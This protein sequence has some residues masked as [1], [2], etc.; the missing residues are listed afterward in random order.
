MNKNILVAAFVKKDEGSDFLKHI[1]SEFDIEA[2]K[3]FEFDIMDDSKQSLYTFYIDIPVGERINL[4]DYFKNALI[5]HKKKK[6]F[7][8]INALNKLIEKE[9]DLVGG[10]ID[11]KK[12]KIN[13][14]KFSNNLIL[15]SNNNL[16]IIQ[17]KRVFS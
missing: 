17:I 1:K 16:S 6:T 13:W 9:Y 14:D 11:Y 4:R 12:Y 8:T 3:V 2:S 5:V 15:N 10:N 7:Y